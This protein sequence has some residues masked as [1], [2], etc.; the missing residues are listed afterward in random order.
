MPTTP[1]QSRQ[2]TGVPPSQEVQAFGWEADSTD[3]G[4]IRV[5]QALGE[6]MVYVPFEPGAYN[7]SLNGST[8]SQKYAAYN[9]PLNTMLSASYTT[10]V[11][12]GVFDQQAVCSFLFR[13]KRLALAAEYR[14]S[15]GTGGTNTQPIQGWVDGQYF[16]ITNSQ[17]D[18]TSFVA[19]T[20]QMKA[21]NNLMPVDVELDDDGPHQCDI[22]MPSDLT[23]TYV[24]QLYGYAVEARTG[25]QKVSNQ[26]AAVISIPLNTANTYFSL[27]QGLSSFG[28]LEKVTIWNTNAAAENLTVEQDGIVIVNLLAMVQNTPF[29]LDMGA[30]ATYKTNNSSGSQ[31]IRAKGSS[32]NLVAFCTVR[33]K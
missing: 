2:I 17:L 9:A 31:Q 28:Q 10:T 30:A 33:T 29:I 3:A 11:Q 14:Q 4:H 8:L 25:A 12:S 16:E 5:Q 26:N 20:V 21:G 1:V 7:N 24:W 19:G 18:A 22:Y 32:V 15:G 27:M 23:S 13:G 6:G